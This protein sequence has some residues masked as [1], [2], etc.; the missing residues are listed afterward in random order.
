MPPLTEEDRQ[1]LTHLWQVEWGGDTMVTRG[2]VYRLTNLHAL[3]CKVSG[4]LAGAATYR[5]DNTGCELMSL[6]ALTQG[7]GV[8]TA[9]VKAVEAEARK[10]GCRRLW[11][12]TSND[13][14]DALRFYQRRGFRIT[15]VYPDAVDEARRMKPTIPLTGENGI[16]IHDEIELAK[17]L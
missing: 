17:A 5:F 14:L 4:K 6:N 1:W 13:N 11:L 7:S 8:G 16:E 3:V 2:Q 12:I 10:T 15:A 9:L